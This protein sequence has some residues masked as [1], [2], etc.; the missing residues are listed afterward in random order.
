VLHALGRLGARGFQENLGRIHA[1]LPTRGDPDTLIRQAEGVLRTLAPE[2]LPTIVWR[3]LDADERVGP[4]G[5]VPVTRVSKRIVLAPPAASPTAEAGPIPAATSIVEASPTP[6]AS[7]STFPD[8][9]RILLE[10]GMAFGDGGHGTTRGALRLLEYRL[11]ARE[12]GA[13]GRVLDLGAGTGVLA[14]AAALLGAFEVIAVE[15]DPLACDQIRRHVKLNG[16]ARRVRVDEREVRAGDLASFGDLNG[17]LANVEQD[18]LRPLLPG[19]AR[20]LSSGGWLVA[21][22]ASSGERGLLIRTALDAGLQLE[23][24]ELDDGWWSGLFSRLASEGPPAGTA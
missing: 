5:P 22:G 1:L 16:V 14:V 3:V 4:S 13:A 19:L 23:R 17:I 24:E 2:S 21:S 7:P 15:R 11:A 12:G 20:A 8:E 9:I 18:I 6:E 10:P